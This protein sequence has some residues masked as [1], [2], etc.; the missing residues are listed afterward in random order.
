MKRLSIL[1]NYF[2][3]PNKISDL[4][5]TKFLD[6]SAKLC[7]LCMFNKLIVRFLFHRLF[8]GR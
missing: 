3:D 8:R 1:H 5:L 7:F 2:D 4:Y 6:I